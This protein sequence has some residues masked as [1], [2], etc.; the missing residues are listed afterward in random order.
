MRTIR[1]PIVYVEWV[2]S[3]CLPNVTWFPISEIDNQ[4]SRIATVGFLVAESKDCIT[5]VRQ[6]GFEENP[7]VGGD[8]TIPK[9]AITK[10]KVL[11]K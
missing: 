5:L 4:V 3:S 8:I 7:G 9:A 10:R 1:F 2:D 6:Y 11:K